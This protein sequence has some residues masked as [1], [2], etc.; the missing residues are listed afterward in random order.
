MVVTPLKCLVVISKQQKKESKKMT[1]KK[2]KKNPSG[3][4]NRWKPAV[5]ARNEHT[6]KTWR[7]ENECELFCYSK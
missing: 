4:M 7:P 5:M 2:I 3:E 6:V 1:K